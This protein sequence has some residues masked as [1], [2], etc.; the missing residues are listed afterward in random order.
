MSEYNGW[1]N[2]A[3]WRVNLEIFDGMTPRDITGRSLLSV[4]ELKE[5]LKEYAE[6]IIESTST[7]GLAR[8]YAL[9]FLSDVEWYEIANN[10]LSD[11]A[12]DED[13]EEDE[14]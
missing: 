10:M 14:E 2:Y 7:D 5:A 3:T 13:S 9:A 8:D 6:E 12:E 4:G 1:K 11:Y